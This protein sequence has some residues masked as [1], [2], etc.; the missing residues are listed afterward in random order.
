MICFNKTIQRLNVANNKFGAEGVAHLLRHL[1]TN[2]SSQISWLNL[3]ACGLQDA[4][5]KVVAET[6][7]ANTVLV[8]VS[9][10]EN[11][12]TNVGLRVLL[13]ALERNKTVEKLSL[14]RNHEIS[15]AADQTII[16]LR[17]SVSSGMRRVCL[18]EDVKPISASGTIKGTI[19]R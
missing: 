4:G 2:T 13:T 7:I 8:T 6:L 16:D 1:K 3:D 18:D 15:A 11:G 10:R 19:K 5:A 14:E 17:A 9:L 12:I